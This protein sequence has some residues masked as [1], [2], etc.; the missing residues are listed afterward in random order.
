VTR[1]GP[2]EEIMLL[3][4]GTRARRQATRER[5]RQLVE[6]LDW[7]RLTEMLRLRGLL[8]TLGPRILQIAGD[9]ALDD[10]TLAVDQSIL[11]GRHQGALLQLVC[12]RI[13]TALAE[14]G[15]RSTTLKGSM[16][17]EAI[18]GD[19]GRRPSRDIDLLVATE[20][21]SAA[22][23]V[24]QALGYRAPRDHV[25]SDGLPTLHFALAHERGELPMVELHWRIHWYERDFAR[26]RLLPPTTDR[27]DAW[28][29]AP[30]DELAALLLFYVRDGFI[31]LRLAADLSAWWDT[32]GARVRPGAL[33]RILDGYPALRRAILAGA[34]VAERVVGVPA[35][36]IFGRAIESDLRC[37]LAVTMANPNPRTNRAQLYADMG[38]V[39]WLL[40]PP[41]DTRGFI[42][43]Q[44][45]I[46]RE[47]RIERAR[48]AENRR[49][50]SLLGYGARVMSRYGLAIARLPL[51]RRCD[52]P[53]RPRIGPLHHRDIVE[54]SLVK[55]A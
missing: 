18:Y 31:G 27:L 40:A 36:Q 32:Y 54:S 43:R 50:A 17:G 47:V 26:M 4:A 41:G 12:A 46:P 37:R 24:V 34:A 8:P 7:R 33:E 39:D 15:I 5:S 6:I 2:E 42:R 16:L 13:M 23:E 28:R 21:L 9:R 55:S 10:F 51:A 1:A 48:H 30:A 25:E 29:P 11:T 3:S 45:L 38:L 14:A 22:A 19:P 53:R 49:V 44:V 35:T 20:Q 52:H